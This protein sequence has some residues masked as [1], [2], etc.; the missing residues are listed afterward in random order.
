VVGVGSYTMAGA[1]IPTSKVRSSF[2]DYGVGRDAA[3]AGANNGRLDLLA[4]GEGIFGLIKPGYDADGA[5]TFQ[6]PGYYWWQGTSMASPAF[7]GFAAMM[8]R[9]VPSLTPDEL[10]N[11]FYSTATSAGSASLGYGYVSPTTAY[12]K[13]KSDYP[14]L[15]APAALAAPTSTNSVRLPLRWSPVA[16]RGVSYDLADN[17]VFVKNVTGVSTILDLSGGGSHQVSVSPRSNYNWWTPDTNK[18]GTVLVDPALEPGVLSGTVT[19]EGSPLGGVAVSVPGTA[20]VTTAS[21]GTYSVAGITPGGYG[22]VYSK[23]GFATQTSTVVINAGSSVTQSVSLNV[24][25]PVYR[26]YNR[27]SASHFYTASE[28]EKATVL[29][30]LSS[31]YSLEGVAYS[32]DTAAAA[33]DAPLYRFYNKQTGAHFY[34]ASA[35]EKANVQVNLSAIY[36]YDGPAYK[37]CVT[38]V[39]DSQTVYRFYNKINGAHFY[40][41]SEAEKNSVIANLSATYVLDGP[42]F[43]L[44]P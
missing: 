23:S 40:T 37:V 1:D 4:P 12:A 44:A 33:N 22:V 6:E 25:M 29:N 31:T 3:A 5:G 15:L 14:Y 38:P 17:G 35:A 26:F 11:V 27:K 16:G 8:W 30:T 24:A 20:T 43:Y 28:A 32:I 2:T 10:A 13:L 36:S 34:T 21:D 9:F 42:A 19:H 41:A 39:A 7:A 18:S